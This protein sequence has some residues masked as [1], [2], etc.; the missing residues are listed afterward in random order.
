MTGH[1]IGTELR[2]NA[3]SVADFLDSLVSLGLLAR[4]GD[5]TPAHYA[6]TSDTAAFLDRRSPAYLGGILEMLSRRGRVA[7]GQG[8]SLVSSR[9]PGRTSPDS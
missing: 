2:L 1:E 9:S 3:R 7:G 8:S 4:H 6:N 5:A